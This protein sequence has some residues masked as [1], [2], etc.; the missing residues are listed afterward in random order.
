MPEEVGRLGA[1]AI[2]VL[3]ILG[4]GSLRLLCWL[5]LAPCCALAPSLSPPP[6]CLLP[7]SP[8]PPHLHPPGSLRWFLSSVPSEVWVAKC[9]REN[10]ERCP[11]PFHPRHEA[12]ATFCPL[13]LSYWGAW[14]LRERHSDVCPWQACCDSLK[15]L[16]IPAVGVWGEGRKF[17]ICLQFLHK[18]ETSTYY[19]VPDVRL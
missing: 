11:C 12:G 17:T 1:R 14:L 4:L 13:L 18:L 8:P 5:R 6:G 2:D 7:S 16:R 15:R 9:L 3:S 19:A 10:S